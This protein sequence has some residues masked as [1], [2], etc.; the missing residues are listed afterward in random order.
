MSIVEKGYE[1]GRKIASN[2]GVLEAQK[3]LN[4]LIQANEH[5]MF[6]HGYSVAISSVVRT[7]KR[8]KLII[9]SE[10]NKKI[11]DNAF[12]QGREDTLIYLHAEKLIPLNPKAKIP[13]D[14][15]HGKDKTHWLDLYVSGI[16][17]ALFEKAK[18]RRQDEQE[19]N[20]EL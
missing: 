15:E 12:K 7:M 14:L 5:P 20:Q 8:G 18:Q 3:E 16:E 11:F 4:R 9:V 6:I 1:A 13:K 2:K 19:H 10:K 17:S